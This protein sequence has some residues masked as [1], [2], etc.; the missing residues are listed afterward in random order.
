M[1]SMAGGAPDKAAPLP[2]ARRA[3]LR[4]L[5]PYLW[6]AGAWDLRVRVLL[7]LACLVV[8]K[9]ANVIIPLIFKGMVDALTVKPGSAAVT[10]LAVPVVLLLA[11][12]AGAHLDPGLRR[13]ARRHLRQGGAA[14]DP[15]RGAA[16]LPAPARAVAA[17]PSGPADR[18]PVPR[19]SSAAPRASS[20]CCSSC[21]STSCRP[22]SRSR[23][24]AASCGGCTTVC[25]A[26]VTFVTIAGY[27]AYTLTV[28]EWRIKFRR[29]MNEADEEANTKAIDSLLN[30][31]TVKYFGNEAH[32]A[33][34][35]D[36]A[37]QAYEQAAVKSRTTLV[38][39]QYRPGRHH[40]RRRDA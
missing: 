19:R 12:G 33:R 27:V 39:A 37:L 34:R 10:V 5:L 35:Y 25:F 28:T 23:W 14:R 24:S 36:V 16:D 8:A 9:F 11:Y 20:S 3:A 30:Y 31:E 15:P 18:R 21:C 6:P 38:G 1:A 7:A 32:E 26:L 29:E 13:T 2:G 22:C 4:Q 40:R 17:L